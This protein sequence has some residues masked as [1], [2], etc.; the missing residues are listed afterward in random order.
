[1]SRPARTK[2]STGNHMSGLRSNRLGLGVDRRRTKEGARG[3]LDRAPLLHVR[4]SLRRG[5]P[6]ESPGARTYSAGAWCG[7]CT[8]PGSASGW[9]PS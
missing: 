6:R 7:P 8:A 1:M 9:M 4:I 5:S 3:R 2:P